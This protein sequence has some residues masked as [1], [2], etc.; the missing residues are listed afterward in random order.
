MATV[1]HKL[2]K[3]HLLI[4]SGD[5]DVVLYPS[6]SSYQI[7]LPEVIKD[8]VGITLV[9]CV[10]PKSQPIINDQGCFID[11]REQ[12][13]PSTFSIR[14]D[15]GNVSAKTLVS[16]LNAA[17]AAGPWVNS[18]A[19]AI[20]SLTSRLIITANGDA[21]PFRL[22]F[23]T[24]PNASASLANI[25]GFAAADTPFA[26]FQKGQRHVNLSGSVFCNVS[27]A[28]VP[29]I[30]TKQVV[31]RDGDKM[32]FRN[33]IARIPLDVNVGFIKY[34]YADQC[35]KLTNYFEPTKLDRLTLT[36]TNDQG[37]PY[38]PD[39]LDHSIMFE[40][41]Q[42]GRTW[43]KE[44]GKTREKVRQEVPSPSASSRRE[45]LRPKAETPRNKTFNR[46]VVA[47]AALVGLGGAAY[48]LLGKDPKED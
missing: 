6:A 1:A 7:T 21:V 14:L 29:R 18:Y 37:S 22:L 16:L 13:N 28:E 27:I 26:L 9:Q 30:A 15:T 11:F 42:L 8:V 35:D 32:G 4:D 44:L 36:L 5:R 46:T 12:G 24:G 17:F 19:A 10:F 47:A 45:V 48:Y 20:E 25:L 39:G 31:F 40:V 33:V 23:K 43:T 34:H 3:S 38:M 2:F 41:S